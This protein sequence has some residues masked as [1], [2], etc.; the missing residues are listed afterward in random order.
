MKRG[1]QRRFISTKPLLNLKR[2]NN[3]LGGYI[4]VGVGSGAGFYYVIGH[5]VVLFGLIPVDYF[6][7]LHVYYSYKRSIGNADWR[8]RSCK[9]ATFH[10][11]A[12]L[13]KGFGHARCTCVHREKCALLCFYLIFNFSH[14]TEPVRAAASRFCSDNQHDRLYVTVNIVQTKINF[15]L[16]NGAVT[17]AIY[18]AGLCPVGHYLTNL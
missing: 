14:L 18:V 11:G 9:V 5:H 13:T 12:N 2:Q 10:V 4:L 17:V 6:A 16:L 3:L 1:F 8:L 7:R 15:G